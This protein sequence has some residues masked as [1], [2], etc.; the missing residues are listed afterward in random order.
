MHRLYDGNTLPKNVTNEGIKKGKFNTNTF[1]NN[2][3]NPDL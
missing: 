3:K 2:I 1:C